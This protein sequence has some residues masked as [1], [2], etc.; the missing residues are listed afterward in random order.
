MLKLYYLPN[1][2]YK[3]YLKLLG[4]P[5]VVQLLIDHDIGWA[6]EARDTLIPL[7]D[8]FEHSPKI[9]KPSENAVPL[10]DS[11]EHPAATR[12]R[13]SLYLVC[14]IY[15]ICIHNLLIFLVYNF[16]STDGHANSMINTSDQHDNSLILTIPLVLMSH[17]HQLG[18][19]VHME[20]SIYGPKKAC[21]SWCSCYRAS[22]N[23]E[24]MG[25]GWP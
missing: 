1:R 10:E 18:L 13:L 14:L 16:L 25:W 17:L 11:F 2:N 7:E 9:A 3:K 4:G 23:K 24:A 5:I 19:L 12:F 22:H 8:F 21:S 20:R 15:F 6:L